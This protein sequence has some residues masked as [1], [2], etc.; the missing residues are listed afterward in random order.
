MAVPRD[1]RL[2][3]A[4]LRST[5]FRCSLCT[6]TPAIGVS[7]RAAPAL[8]GHVRVCDASGGGKAGESI[9]SFAW[10]GC[11]Q[12]FGTADAR[13]VP[14]QPSPAPATRAGV[15]EKWMTSNLASSTASRNAIARHAK[16]STRS[17]TAS[18][19]ARGAMHQRAGI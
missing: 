2:R 12:H 1:E 10:Q 16:C 15:A 18:P 5:R 7:R 9:T 3:R 8:Q 6:L 4:V 17:S 19:M 14:H 11:R 13:L